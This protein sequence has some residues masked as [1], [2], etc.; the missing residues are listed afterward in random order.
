MNS[1]SLRRS[2]RRRH[3][4][5]KKGDLVEIVRD[6]GVSTGRLLRKA[7]DSS[8]SNPLWVFSYVDG[9]RKNEEIPEK[10]LG[11]VIDS[12]N[13]SAATDNLNINDKKNRKGR[14][15]SKKKSEDVEVSN[16]NSSD[17]TSSK[18]GSDRKSD[19][20][21]GKKRRGESS[22]DAQEHRLSKRT[23]TVS[24][25]QQPKTHQRTT[26]VSTRSSARNNPTEELIVPPTDLMPERRGGSRRGGPRPSRK[27]DKNQEV[28]KVK[29]LTGTL[30]LYRGEHRR[31]E[32]I[33]FV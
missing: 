21:S 17:D 29:L 3:T 31:A 33:R 9:R 28:V 30:Y 19:D 11:K 2:Q 23:K 22:S 4:T 7:S 32:F 10:S 6:S 20:A 1:S 14:A 18:T 26:R 27:P 16:S 15:S 25:K 8:S 24:F 13:N 5:Y 12:D